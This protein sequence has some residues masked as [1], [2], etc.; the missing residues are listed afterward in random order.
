M[1]ISYDRKRDRVVMNCNNYRKFSKYGICCSHFI[2]YEKLTNTIYSKIR[3]MSSLYLNDKKEFEK[4]INENYL[5]PKIELNKKIDSC[6]TEINNLRKKQDAIY[7]D[8]FNGVIDV[9]T[10]QRLFNNINTEISTLT[11]KVGKYKKELEEVK[12]D[13]ISYIEYLD[14]VENFLNIN[15]PTKE[16]LNKIIERI[17]ITKNKDVEIHYRIKKVEVL[18]T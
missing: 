11:K 10:Y 4:I 14:V 9:D 8:K 15:N 7:D 13:S 16:M 3:E 6:K 1:T 5:D 12:E 18:V 2:N 17:Y